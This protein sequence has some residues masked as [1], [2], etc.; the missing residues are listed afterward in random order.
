MGRGEVNAKSLSRRQFLEI[1]GRTGLGAMVLTL[2]GAAFFSAPIAAEKHRKL[3][4]INEVHLETREITWEL[5]RGKRIKAMAYNG[6]IP[7]PE[8]RFKE[9]ERVRIV[10]KNSLSEP[11]TI[12]W[13][14]VD[15]PNSMDGVPEITQKPVQPGATFVYEFE[16]KPA[17][18]RWYHTHFEEHRQLDLGLYAPI[19]IEPAGPEPFPFDREYT[20]MLEDWVT[21]KGTVVASTAEGTG[22]G[23][24]RMGGMMGGMMG[25]RMGRMMN[26]MMGGGHALRTTRWPSMAEPIRKRTR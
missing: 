16:A 5:A 12:H 17:G 11:T 9:G 19:I 24:G 10:L 13:H 15:V 4:G 8:L 1:S 14:G 7:G 3:G 20:L 26:R 22:A 21:G 2:G 25:G 6:K 23:R 18:T